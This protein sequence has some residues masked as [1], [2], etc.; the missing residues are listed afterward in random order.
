M[1]IIVYYL[2]EPSD[3]RSRAETLVS[4]WESL[5]TSAS[6]IY[7]SLSQEIQPSFFQL[8]L[9]PVRAGLIVTKMWISSGMNS[10][11]TVQARLSANNYA[12]DV[13]SLFDMDY[14]LEHEYH[15]ILNGMPPVTVF[16]VRSLMF[17]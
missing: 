10:L 2:E 15:T 12:D 3:S 14:D 4:Q 16:L 7:N 13:E 5:N 17:V 1:R 6:R 8:V 9:H 11:R